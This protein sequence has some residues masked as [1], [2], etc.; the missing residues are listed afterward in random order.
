[1]LALGNGVELMERK[2]TYGINI[3]VG[4]SG[5]DGLMQ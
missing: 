2:A 3:S 5:S 1:M 4:D